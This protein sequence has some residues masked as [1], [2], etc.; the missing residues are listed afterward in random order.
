MS[1][2]VEFLFKVVFVIWIQLKHFPA[3]KEK[4]MRSLFTEIG[5]SLHWVEVA[6]V[7]DSSF[8][9]E[10]NKLVKNWNSRGDFEQNLFDNF[11]PPEMLYK[12]TKKG[13]W[14]DNGTETLITLQN[15]NEITEQRKC[16][17]P[18]FETN[19]YLVPDINQIYDNLLYRT[20]DQGEV[21]PM[22]ESGTG[23]YVGE[24]ELFFDRLL[25]P[26]QGSSYFSQFKNTT[27]ID[28]N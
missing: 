25:K 17:F 18:T 20:N 28:K 23:A 16:C 24:L 1:Q 13:F 7:K 2:V 5:N 10:I 14:V 12:L 11:N 6:L 19:K 4:E 22:G 15:S 3:Q 8:E 27:K 26:F 21:L 9:Q